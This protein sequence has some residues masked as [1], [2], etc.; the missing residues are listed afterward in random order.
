MDLMSLASHFQTVGEGNS[1]F[2]FIVV[3]YR[4]NT[5]DNVV[6]SIRYEIERLPIEP[7]KPVLFLFGKNGLIL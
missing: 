3:S 5:L 4:Q 1:S 2:L 7:D 6:R